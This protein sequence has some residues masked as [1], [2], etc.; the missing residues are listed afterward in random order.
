LNL[1]VITSD[2]KKAELVIMARAADDSL[3]NEIRHKLAVLAEVLGLQHDIPEG[4]PG[5]AYTP[6]SKLRD[7]MKNTLA[8]HGLPYQERA[9]HGGLEC[10]RVKGLNPD[11]D[12]ITFGPIMEMIHSPDERLELQ[13]FDDGY[14]ILV[15]MIKACR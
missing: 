8:S 6:H 2:E 3:L 5:W 14:E 9:T 13:S 10:G 1:G 4:Y 7:I 11:M 15:E 12:I